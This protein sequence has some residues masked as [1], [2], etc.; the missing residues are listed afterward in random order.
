LTGGGLYMHGNSSSN[1]NNIIIRNLTIVGSIDDNIGM[2]AGASH[3]WIDHCTF[4]DASDGCMDYVKGSDWLTVSWCKFYYTSPSLDHRLACLISSS[5]DDAAVDIG[6]LH[7]TF[8]HNW[9]GS[10]CDQRMPSVRFG[11]VHA[12]NN[13]YSAAGNL[14]CI[15]SRLYSECR[16]ENNYFDSVGNPWEVYLTPAGGDTGKVYAVDNTLV[17][18]TFTP[19]SDP[20]EGLYSIIVPGTDTVFA[21]PYSYNLDA[22]A[23]VPDSVTNYAGAGKGPF[24]P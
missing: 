14:Y 1:A 21:A 12:F 23:T 2:T 11:R 9:F 5:D 19:A 10:N 6:K 17:N 7:V 20:D 22:A 15:R 18:C 3:I 24:A 16:V 13:Y 4:V 8:H